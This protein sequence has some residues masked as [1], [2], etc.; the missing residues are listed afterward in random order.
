MIDPRTVTKFDRTSEELEEFMLFSIVVAGKGAFQQAEKLN[1]FLASGRMMGYGNTPF[2]LV[3]N[4]DANGHLVEMLKLVKMGQ[5]ERI[6]TAFR[7][8]AHFFAHDSPLTLSV[9]FLECIKGIGM[10]T[11]R[12]FFM[13]SLEGQQYACLDTH[14]L[15]WLSELG[16]ADVPKTTPRGDKYLQLE[17]IFLQHARHLGK[18][19][20][21][22]DLEIWNSQHEKSFTIPLTRV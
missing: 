14:I 17:S 21:T 7:G 19:P 6:S 11:A 4:M 8:V 12:F 13:H 18:S 2:Q 10:K 15:K 16:Y 3:R 20:A 22:L 9:K 5:Y 1:Q